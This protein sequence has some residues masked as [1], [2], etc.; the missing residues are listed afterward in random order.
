MSSAL[1]SFLE[2]PADTLP[3]DLAASVEADGAEFLTANLATLTEALLNTPSTIAGACN[4]LASVFKDEAARDLV[5]QH[6]ALQQAVVQALG[7]A[8]DAQDSAARIQVLRAIGNMCYDH[9]GNR[10]ALREQDGVTQLTKAMAALSN[11]GDASD[12]KSR[13]VGA[14]VVINTAGDEDSDLQKDLVEHGVIPSLLWLLSAA[15]T[16]TELS[17]SI[18]ALA[19]FHRDPKAM[20]QAATE[21]SVRTLCDT[22]HGMRDGSVE[23]LDQDPLYLS[24]GQLL[25][26][27]CKQDDTLH[28]F[29]QLDVLQQLLT[30]AQTSST[31]VGEMAALCLSVTLGDD[32]CQ[33]L[34]WHDDTRSTLLSQFVAWL[35]HT[36]PELNVAGAIAIGN[37]CRSDDNAKLLG[38]TPGLLLQ[39]RTMLTSHLSFVQHASLSALKNLLTLPANRPLLRTPE[40]VTAL[41]TVINDSQAPLQYLSCSMFRVVLLDQ[42]AD[43]ITAMLEVQPEILPRLEHLSKSEA[44]PVRSEATRAFCMMIKH[45]QSTAIMAQ[46]AQ[47]NGV[48][49]IVR[50]LKA[51]HGMLQGEAVMALALLAA[52]NDD[53]TCLDALVDSKALDGLTELL[54]SETTPPQ[55]ACNV[56][57]LLGQFLQH[58]G[59]GTY[60]DER[61]QAHELLTKLTNN[62]NLLV[63]QHAQAAA[64]AV[65]T[66]TAER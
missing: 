55:L 20:A 25:R 8:T 54:A 38:E 41:Y 42:S 14:G 9:D 34:L 19:R 4:V 15:E 45:S 66:T 51:P 13:L 6:T 48:D 29:A 28:A 44:P 52:A 40:G 1:V 7:Q 61:T 12:S 24:V 43:V 53:Q 18:Q 46:I 62:D 21:A 60:P 30:T 17:M 58:S 65:A 31:G 63:Q 5:E 35:Q 10:K 59:I 39:L 47:V 27:I 16:E 32:G 26:S 33:S 37:V 56:G 57:T 22:L 23:D 64:K 2:A 50:L 11:D 3:D 36:N 49:A